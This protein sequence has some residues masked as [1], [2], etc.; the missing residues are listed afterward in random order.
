[1]YFLLVN[2]YKFIFTALVIND[3]QLNGVRTEA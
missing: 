3:Q 1:M 2:V